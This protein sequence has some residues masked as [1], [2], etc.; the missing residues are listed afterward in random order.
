MDE[1]LLLQNGHIVEHGTHNE[2]LSKQ[3]LYGRMWELYNQVI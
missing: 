1:I 2:L 3:G